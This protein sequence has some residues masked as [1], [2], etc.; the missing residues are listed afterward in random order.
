MDR[1][2]VYC[3]KDI[4]P[5]Q[6]VLQCSSCFN[7]QHRICKTEISLEQYRN[8][9]KLKQK[10]EWK[11]EQC[12]SMDN[13]FELPILNSTPVYLDGRA[14]EFMDIGE[15][16]IE[17][18][19]SVNQSDGVNVFAIANHALSVAENALPFAV[20]GNATF[21]VEDPGT[22]LTRPRVTEEFVQPQDM[23]TI[24]IPTPIEESSIESVAPQDN[25]SFVEQEEFQVVESSSQRGKKKLV[26]GRGFTY[27]VKRETQK[28]ILWRC[29]VRS[30]G[31]I[32]GCTIGFNHATMEYRVNGTHHHP[33]T[34]GA[35][36]HLRLQRDV[37][38]K[39]LADVFRPASSIV[40]EVM[41]N[42]TDPTRPGL[43]NPSN[44]TRMANR[45]RE[46]LRP[47]D[48]K[49]LN[50]TVDMSYVPS[51]FLRADIAV[52]GRRHLL[53]ATDR[54]IELLS[55]AKRWYMDGTFK[56]IRHPFTQL[57]SIHGFI[58][59][60]E[61]IKQVPLAFAMMSGKRKVD[62]IALLEA[63]KELVPTAR[64]AELMVDF[65]EA[66]WRAVQEVFP[67]L[68][69]RGCNFH[70]AQAVWRKVQEL[71]LVVAFRNDEGTHSLVKKL[72]ALPYLPAE[73]IPV[74]FQGL[75]A[76]ST[77]EGLGELTQY[78]QNTW[79]E[80]RC[81]W[82]PRVWSHYMQSIRTNNDLEG[83]HRRINS[84]ANGHSQSFYL[85][86]KLIHDE[87]S[88]LQLQMRLVSEDMLSRYQRNKYKNLQAKLFQHC[89]SF[90]QGEITSYQLLRRCK[91]LTPS[92]DA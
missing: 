50:F 71:G 36:S 77:T 12:L 27:T 38:S 53:F 22:A 54:Q 41:T 24:V 7:W 37:K 57:V 82:A 5:K 8:A 73:H 74:V 76:R 58:R 87:A 56:V 60:T 42:V 17:P 1:C 75:Q 4:R 39:A 2:C 66:T 86:I 78:I 84:K 3:Q 63:I 13:A 48:P 67:D 20:A 59:H 30:K 80:S 64:V 52:E 31:N 69:I 44:L 35:A 89:E 55:V 11:C 46:K 92:L 10:I 26:D 72:L 29:S 49:D 51:D 25:N 83:W 45:N 81:L 79:I 47:A 23:D 61:S 85:L 16:S 68:Q 18:A 70:W 88:L 15:S 33:P 65:E 14:P 19:S 6:H 9:Q 43:S 91:Y 62:Y 28:R 32:C 40:N 34:S 21:S 90:N